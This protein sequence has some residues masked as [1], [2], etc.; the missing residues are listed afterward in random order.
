MATMLSEGDKEVLIYEQ[1]KNHIIYLV[2]SFYP[3]KK[4]FSLEVV[5]Q[6][7]VENIKKFDL[8]L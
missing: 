5:K 7:L 8:K 3:E 4:I 2:N 1:F 6:D